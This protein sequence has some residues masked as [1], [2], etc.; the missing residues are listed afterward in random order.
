M[1][2]NTICPTDT[3]DLYSNHSLSMLAYCHTMPIEKFESVETELPKPC[4]KDGARHVYETVHLVQSL[5]SQIKQIVQP[6]IQRNAYFAHPE[7]LLLS[8]KSDEKMNIRE[9]GLRRLL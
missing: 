6:V 5:P 2:S 9:L 1:N 7:N 4:C 3:A 8:M